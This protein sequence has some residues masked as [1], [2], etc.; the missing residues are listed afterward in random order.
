MNPDLVI[1]CVFRYAA[2][3]KRTLQAHHITHVLNAADVKF[4]K[5][6]LSSP[7]DKQS[8]KGLAGVGPLRW[9]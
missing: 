6:A 8:I 9:V 5:T 1:F 3:D 2:K 7:N 4:I